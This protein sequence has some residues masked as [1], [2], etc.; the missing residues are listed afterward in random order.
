MSRI[1]SLKEYSF[2]QKLYE[3]TKLKLIKINFNNIKEWIS[4]SKGNNFK[5]YN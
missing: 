3:V 1:A 4:Y 2:M 5:I